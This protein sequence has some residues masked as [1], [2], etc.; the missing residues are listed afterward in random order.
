MTTPD[1]LPPYSTESEQAILGCLLTDAKIAYP[2]CLERIG[3][4]VEYFYD[5]KHRTLYETIS[6]M[7][8]E[9][10]PVSVLSVYEQLKLSGKLDECGSLEYLVLL[11]EKCASPAGVDFFARIVQDLGRKRQVIA[12]ATDAASRAFDLRTDPA[13]II[14]DASR[15]LS[16]ISRA[17]ATATP[18][19]AELIR[20]AIDEIETCHQ[21]QGKLPGLSTGYPDLDKKLNG[22]H[23]GEMIVIA[24]RPSM[25][26]TSLAMN[27][28]EH[29]AVDQGVP[30]GVF[31]LEMTA[32]ALITRMLC[33]R[34]RINLRAV[35]D[36]FMT[37]RDFPKIV[38]AAG[39]IKNAVLT[40]DD[41]S[42]LSIH[43][44]NAR[45][46][47]MAEKFGIKLLVIDYLQLISG[48]ARKTDNRQSE[49]SEISRGCKAIAKQLG[50]PVIVLSQLNREMEKDKNRR[51]RLSDLRESGAIEQ[52]AD[53]VAFLWRPGEKKQKDDDGEDDGSSLELKLLLISK[54]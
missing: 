19:I 43:E 9:H 23:D 28:A 29:V 3:A 49:V 44:I 41:G 31:S 4:N 5:L 18:P 47:G 38:S 24:A 37:E 32:G 17:E 48:G 45:A 2:A 26:K 10:S 34:A 16:G 35:S 52:D 46:E 7:I 1:R 6:R 33:S 8:D 40:I 51:P 53:V 39:K 25:G 20:Q 12:L 30:V 36:G 15:G 54:Q 42:G 11:P 22:L 21:Q 13:Q 50:I 27:I 14:A